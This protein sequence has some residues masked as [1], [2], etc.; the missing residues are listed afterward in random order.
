MEY[1]INING[2]TFDNGSSVVR[3]EFGTLGE[4]Y[5]MN[6]ILQELQSIQKTLERTEPMVAGAISDLRQAIQI[7]DNNRISN[8]VKN[9]SSGL[10]ASVITK[11][12]SEGLLKWLGIH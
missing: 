2:S 6:K 9:L 4:S 1:K 7:N 12:A 5:E 10:A 8:I 11:L 3:N